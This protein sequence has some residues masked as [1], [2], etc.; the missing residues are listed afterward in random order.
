MIAIP[1]KVAEGLNWVLG[2]FSKEIIRKCSILVMNMTMVLDACAP[3]LRFGEAVK[4]ILFLR[5]ECVGLQV[6][7]RQ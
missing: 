3:P 6:T 2:D 5:K 4:N 7:I 1:G